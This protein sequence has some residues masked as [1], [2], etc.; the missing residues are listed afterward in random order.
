[1]NIAMTSSWR[2]SGRNGLWSGHPGGEGVV[3]VLGVLSFQGMDDAVVEGGVRVRVV[4]EGGLC[5]AE[6]VRGGCGSNSDRGVWRGGAEGV[7]EGEVAGADVVGMGLPDQDIP[8]PAEPVNQPL[9][10]PFRHR[11]G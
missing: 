4:G 5:Q 3:S 7:E 8:H 9:R 11:G 10:E 2:R 6:A 1:M